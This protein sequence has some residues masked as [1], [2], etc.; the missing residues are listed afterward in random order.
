M[1]EKDT[2]KK[3]QTGKCPT[4]NAP[5]TETDNTFFPFCS[6]QCQLVDLNKWFGGEYKIS[7]PI[8][9]ADLDEV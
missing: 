3:P 4:C 6:R 2:S 5:T 9:Q 8:E 7:R 1:S